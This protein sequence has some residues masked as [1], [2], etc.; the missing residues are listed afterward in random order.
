MSDNDPIQTLRQ[1]TH[2]IAATVEK[3]RNVYLAWLLTCIGVAS[4]GLTF[5]LLYIN[6]QGIDLQYTVT[7]G[8]FIPSVIVYLLL[9]RRYVAR[10]QNEYM[11]AFARAIGFRA[12]EKGCFG[13]SAAD[14]H[15]ILPSHNRSRLGYG[16]Q[17]QYRGTSIAIQEAVL[18]E[19]RQD[20]EYR[21]REK[22]FLRFWG[23]LVRIPLARTTDG[24]TV[25]M[26]HAA[27]QTFFRG[28]FNNY[29]K[30]K[31]ADGAFERTYVVLGTDRV[32]AKFIVNPGFKDRFLGAKKTL[33]AYWGEASFQDTE[34]MLA[35][36]RIRPF[37]EVPPL[38][39]PVSE[40]MI[41]QNADDLHSLFKLID[42]LKAKNQIKL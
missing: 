35:F 9:G 10:A 23:L 7:F 3:L 22:E 4:F 16:L 21:N 41:R 20:P 29:E 40:K 6:P 25:V 24:H 26:P 42:I 14:R 15:K 32:D 33:K 37:A 13:I 1:N 2:R 11:N 17:G 27:L 34:I 19:L 18:T 31:T 39:K 28:R 8:A 30:I 5:L 36:Q 12:R 38:W